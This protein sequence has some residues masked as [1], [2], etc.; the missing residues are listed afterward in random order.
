MNM[1]TTFKSATHT[2]NRSGAQALV[3]GTD[4]TGPRGGTSGNWVSGQVVAT[5]RAV[6]EAWYIAPEMALAICEAIGR[7]VTGQDRKVRALMARENE[8]EMAIW[9]E[10]EKK[11]LAARKDDLARS[12]AA[13]DLARAEADRQRCAR[14]NSERAIELRAIAAEIETSTGA[15]YWRGTTYVAAIDANHTIR[16]EDAFKRDLAAAGITSYLYGAALTSAQQ[17]IAAAIRAAA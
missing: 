13:Y 6:D 7:P 1:N 4:P 16:I 5:G 3:V 8:L 17:K 2:M 14:E 12:S 11:A 15:V 9:C 10:R